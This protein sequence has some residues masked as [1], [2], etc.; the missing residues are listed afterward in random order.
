MS[1]NDFKVVKTSFSRK[2][3]LN[4]AAEALLPPEAS[5]FSIPFSIDRYWMDAHCA[6]KSAS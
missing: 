4:N 1:K 2:Y 5:I 3:G 6:K